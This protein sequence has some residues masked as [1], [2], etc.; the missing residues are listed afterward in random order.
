ME[1]RWASRT[2]F[3]TAGMRTTAGHATMAN[4]VP[5]FDSA[6]VEQ[7]RCAGANYLEQDNH[8]NLQA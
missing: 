3:F 4:F 6:M 2:S 5:E 1:F 7:L 8:D